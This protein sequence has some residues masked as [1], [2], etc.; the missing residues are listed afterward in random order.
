MGRNGNGTGCGRCGGGLPVA[1]DVIADLVEQLDRFLDTED[2]D[3]SVA[4]EVLG[5]GGRIPR[6]LPARQARRIRRLERKLRE[7]RGQMVAPT[8]S[9]MVT[10]LENPRKFS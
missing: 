2:V 10:I 9:E 5:G 3:R 7:L 1:M 6:T 8:R 4:V